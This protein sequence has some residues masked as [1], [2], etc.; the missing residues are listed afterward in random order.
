MKKLI[1]ASAI[2]A[3]FTG[4]TAFAA[5]FTTTVHATSGNDWTTVGAGWSSGAGATAGNTYEAKTSAGTTVVRSPAATGAFNFPGDQLI[6]D[7]VGDTVLANSTVT[8][9]GGTSTVLQLKGGGTSTYNFNS[10]SGNPGL[11]LNGGMVNGGFAGSNTTYTLGGSIQVATTSTLNTEEGYTGIT[12][13]QFAIAGSL[14]G[15]G[16]LQVEG[17]TNATRTFSLQSINVTSTNN[18]FTG[19][20]TVIGGYLLG[21]GT[22]SLGTG[23]ISLANHSQLE[24]DYSLNDSGGSLTLTGSTYILDLD[25]NWTFGAVSLNGSSVAAGTYTEAELIALGIGFT[26]AN[27]GTGLSSTGDQIGDGITFAN[28]TI[29]I[30]VVPEPSSLALLGLGVVGL[31]FVVR[32]RLIA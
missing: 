17:D 11:I 27:F 20:W 13:E 21:S 24:T 7:G 10:V 29:T 8:I 1:L 6:L 23:A 12:H 9:T 32:R 31:L 5:S 26:S 15:S 30:A 22:G 18:S 28:A 16:N 19:G 4:T 14:S 3:L 25:Q 2:A